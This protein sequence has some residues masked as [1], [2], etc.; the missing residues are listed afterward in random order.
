MTKKYS[1]EVSYE[2]LADEIEI[3]ALARALKTLPGLS[4]VDILDAQVTVKKV[5]QDNMPAP[6]TYTKLPKVAGGRERD[7]IRRI[8][9]SNYDPDTPKHRQEN[10]EL[11]TELAG[12][13]N[14]S[15]NSIA[16]MAR[17]IARTDGMTKG[18]ALRR[19]RM[20]ALPE[21]YPPDT[22]VMTEPKM[23]FSGTYETEHGH[24]IV[25]DMQITKY[26]R[27][28]GQIYMLDGSSRKVVVSGSVTYA[29]HTY[30]FLPEQCA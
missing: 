22:P 6:G 19:M 8:E 15:E 24:T 14:L 21:V 7:K 25:E 10:A 1:I 29:G 2:I 5:T 20:R 4:N 30:E 23:T 18:A 16:Q 12:M 13:L 3:H 17:S 9:E 11:V 26:S 27:D 28:F